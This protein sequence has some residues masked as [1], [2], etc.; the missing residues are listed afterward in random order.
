VLRCHKNDL[1]YSS[2][3]ERIAELVSLTDRIVDGTHARFGD[4]NE[5]L[6]E[7][8][9]LISD[10]SGL[11]H[12]FLLLDRPIVL[13]PYDFDRFDRSIGFF[14]DYRNDA[15]GAWCTSADMVLEAINFSVLH[16]GAD[17]AKRE[18]LVRRIFS[19]RDGHSCERISSLLSNS[20][21]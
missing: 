15:P 12:D 20:P 8:D 1:K 10:Y 21:N 13:V 6:P 5:L 19:L 18:R 17:S 7:V 3:R 4:V 11:M 2:V 16:P 9:V 14:Y